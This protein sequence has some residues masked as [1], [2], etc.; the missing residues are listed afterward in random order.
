MYT[1]PKGTKACVMNEE[2][3]EGNFSKAFT[4][5][6]ELSFF[7]TVVDPIRIH[8]SLANQLGHPKIYNDLAK[9]G[10]A[11]FRDE[12]KPHYTIAVEYK[13]IGVS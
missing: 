5:T 13:L 10:F 4:T 8:N 7:D 1:I 11:I 2:L 3:A 12:D 6:K 9:V